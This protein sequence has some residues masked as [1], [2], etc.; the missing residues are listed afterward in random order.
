[1]VAEKEAVGFDDADKMEEAVVLG[2]GAVKEEEDALFAADGAEKKT[3]SSPTTACF[4]FH[5][6]SHR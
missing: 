3:P 5:L 4:F 6:L 1:M 2:D